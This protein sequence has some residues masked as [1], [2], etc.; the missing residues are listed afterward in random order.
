MN[1]QINYCTIRIKLLIKT[2]MQRVSK[3]IHISINENARI[4]VLLM[5]LS[6][7]LHNIDSIYYIY[8]YIWCSTSY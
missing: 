6:S 4:M 3:I 1:L 5:F 8:I 7:N 2:D